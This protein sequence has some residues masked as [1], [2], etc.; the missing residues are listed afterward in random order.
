MRESEYEVS[1][2]NLIFYLFFFKYSS[3]HCL[4]N[5]NKNKIDEG[6]IQ[7]NKRK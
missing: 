5:V 7:N 3:E 4:I 2:N 6:I 1:K